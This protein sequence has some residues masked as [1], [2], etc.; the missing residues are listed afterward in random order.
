M[1]EPTFVPGTQLSGAFYAQVV[2]PL[3]GSRPHGA[4]LLGWGSDVLGFDTERST[5]HGW[6]PRVLVFLA[7]HDA[8]DAVRSAVSAELPERFRGWPVRFG[9]DAVDPTDHV[10]ITTLPTWLLD[11]LGFDA[12]AGMSTLDWL[13][14]PQQQLLGV[15]AGRVYVDP[16]GE[17]A[18]VRTSL[19]W[20]PD[21][22]WRWLLACLWH[23]LAQE[24]AFVARATEVGDEAGSAVVAARLVRDTMRLAMLIDR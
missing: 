21:Q 7:E 5:D 20:Y 9:W 15:T 6:G 17:L 24:E 23:R 3:V 11:H 19:A 8:V 14:T 22:V 1:E 18:A 13:L 12:T 4:A 16:T 10:T 2:R